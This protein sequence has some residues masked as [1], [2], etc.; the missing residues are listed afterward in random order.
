MSVANLLGDLF[1][2]NFTNVEARIKNWWSGVSPAIQALIVTVETNEG[3]ILQSLVPIA[4]K[5]VLA[6][7]LTTASFV[8]AIKDVGAQLLEKNVIMA[9][10]TITAALNAEVGTQAAAAGVAVP[11]NSG[12]A[13]VAPIAVPA[14]S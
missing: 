6:G 5:D 8:A 10:T 11:T 12:T 14:A 2:G 3:Q 9:N 13:V 7:G 4:A 1:S